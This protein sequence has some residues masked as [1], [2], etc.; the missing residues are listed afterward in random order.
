MKFQDFQ[1]WSLAKTPLMI[2]H[3]C[4]YYQSGIWTFFLWIF[5]RLKVTWKSVNKL[6]VGNTQI[7]AYHSS[8]FLYRNEVSF[9]YNQV[10]PS[11]AKQKKSASYVCAVE[12]EYNLIS[13]KTKCQMYTN[14][15]DDSTI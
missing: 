1:I 8:T 11:I 6:V 9:F 10:V 7:C 3:I 12:C 4:V 13:R 5:I 14:I 15:S 2:N